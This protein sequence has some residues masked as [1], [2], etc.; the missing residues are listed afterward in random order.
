MNAEYG[1]Y[2]GQVGMWGAVEPDKRRRTR[3]LLFDKA[4]DNTVGPTF[5]SL[6]QRVQDGALVICKQSCR[7][8][9]CDAR[10]FELVDVVSL[11][12]NDFQTLVNT[13]KTP[14]RSPGGCYARVRLLNDS[15]S[16]SVGV[17][18]RVRSFDVFAQHPMSPD[19]SIAGHLQM[20]NDPGGRSISFFVNRD[21]V[22]VLVEKE[23]PHIL[24]A[25]VGESPFPFYHFFW[26]SRAC[27]AVVEAL[28]AGLDS[29][30][31]Q[32]AYV[33]HFGMLC[34]HVSYKAVVLRIP[35]TVYQLLPFSPVNDS[36]R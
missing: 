1:V 26:G 9:E 34:C 23:D 16:L 36:V 10:I 19:L 11:A 13:L 2:S 18:K 33:E 6:Q 35:Y 21:E 30:H 17:V 3:I 29:S 27:D 14:L 24:N 20:R 4:R 7:I 28:H 22:A 8:D 15:L 5:P 31:T 32:F 12:D 25:V